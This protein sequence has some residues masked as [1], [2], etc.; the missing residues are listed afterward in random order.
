[1]SGVVIKVGIYGFLRLIWLLRC[2]PDFWAIVLIAAGAVSGVGGVLLALAQHDLKRLLAYHSVEN[3]GIIALGLGLGCLGLSHHR[4][5]LALL[6]FAG[7]ILHTLNHALFKSLLF[8]GSGAFYQA[9]GTREIEAGGGLLR[10]MPWT[11]ALSLIAAAAIS[12]IPPLNGF[13]SEWLVY[14]ASTSTATASEARLAAAAIASLALIGGLALACFTKAYGTLCLGTPRTEA[15]RS[16][17][18]PGLGMIIP[19]AALAALCVFIGLFPGPALGLVEGAAALV[20]GADAQAA[21]LAL[22]G[23]IVNARIIGLLGACVIVVGC[24]LAFLRFF[25]LQGRVLRGATWGCGFTATTARMQY[26]A[27]SFAQPITRAVAPA[28]GVQTHFSAP[29]GYWPAEA[30]FSTHTPDRV[31]DGLLIP[32]GS[33]TVG[34]LAWIKRRQRSRLQYYMLSVALFLLIL[35]IWKL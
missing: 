1:M 16:A 30:D 9:L 13:V 26:T 8:L 31:L 14:M 27:S 23:F 29:Q 6:G 5:E 2:V 21:R 32:L 12:G 25:L 18:D 7:A 17:R 20:C 35:L 19:M 3:I 33:G 34:L 11:A 4:P 28:L 22:A 15:A 10:M 24:V